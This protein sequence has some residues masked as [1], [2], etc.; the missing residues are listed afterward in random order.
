[1]LLRTNFSAQHQ[2]ILR[3]LTM[4]EVDHLQTILFDGKKLS[5]I[6]REISLED[7][8]HNRTVIF[9]RLRKHGFPPSELLDLVEHFEEQALVNLFFYRTDNGEDVRMRIGAKRTQKQTRGDSDRG[10]ARRLIAKQSESAKPKKSMTASEALAICLRIMLRKLK[11]DEKK[12]NAPA[13]T[14]NSIPRSVIAEIAIDLLESCVMRNH[15]PGSSLTDLFRELL[16]VDTDKPWLTQHWEEQQFAASTISRFPTISTRELARLLHVNPSTISRWRNSSEF[17]Q[18]VEQARQ[19][20]ASVQSSTASVGQR[21]F[22][23]S[24]PIVQR[25]LA[26][27]A[28]SIVGE[29]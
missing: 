29:R 18:K 14:M 5:F 15:P 19:R 28:S 4:T 25:Y 21:D 13:R 17:K 23:L 27:R 22:Q 3:E 20:R 1:M 16:D 8:Q 2:L 7:W 11:Y 9:E 10:R 6:E 24:D 26:F 12:R